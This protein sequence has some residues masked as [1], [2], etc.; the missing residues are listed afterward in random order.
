MLA[1]Y[2]YEKETNNLYKFDVKIPRR[3]KRDVKHSTLIRIIDL[4]D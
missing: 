4:F 2:F 1:D 3:T